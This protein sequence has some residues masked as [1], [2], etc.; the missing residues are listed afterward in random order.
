MQFLF[1][2]S[3]YDQED[4]GLSASLLAPVL[5]KLIMG[6]NGNAWIDNYKDSSSFFYQRYVDDPFCSFKNPFARC[7]HR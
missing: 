7:L 6:Q 3:F 1:K 2:G 5:V 4:D